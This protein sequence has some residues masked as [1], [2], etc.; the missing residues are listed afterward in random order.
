M[1]PIGKE[2]AALQRVMM[3][4]DNSPTLLKGYLEALG[5]VR[6]KFNQIKNQGDPGPAVKAL[7]ASTLDGG[8]SELANVL[9]YVD[10]QM[11]VGMSES[12]RASLRPLLVRPLVQAFAVMTPPVE[13]ELNRLWVAQVHEPFSRTLAA[14]YPFDTASRIEAGPTEI[15]KV[16]GADGAIAKFANDGLGTLVVRRGDTIVPRTWADVGI[17]SLIHI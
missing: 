14:K 2:F 15:A 7:M 11:L 4:R 5:K 6:S 12:A 17:L 9:K 1:G 16:F 3:S 13:T 10:E 8:D